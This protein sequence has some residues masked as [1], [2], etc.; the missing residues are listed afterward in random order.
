M[1]NYLTVENGQRNSHR[2]LLSF[3]Y[4]RIEKQLCTDNERDSCNACLH[5]E[6][7]IEKHP[8]QLGFLRNLELVKQE[9]HREKINPT[10]PT[11]IVFLGDSITEQWNGRMSGKFKDGWT[12]YKT[13]FDE[14]FNDGALAL[15]VSGD[16]VSRCQR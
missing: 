5:K 12:Q 9:I 8:R 4:H 7:S 11:N 13:L 10:L 14:K 1:T 3:D 6:D 2:S 16:T 15:G